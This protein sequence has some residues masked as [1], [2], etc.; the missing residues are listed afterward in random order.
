M[1]ITYHPENDYL[2]PDL[3]VP[4]APILGKYGMLRRR[5]LQQ[6]HNGLYTGLQL[7]GKLESHLTEIDQQATEMVDRL[8]NQLA[9]QQ[10][11]TE[12]LKASDQMQWVGLMNNCK[13]QAEA[14]VLRELIYQ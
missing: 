12:Q 9:Q 7:S 3:T 1:I 5:Y 6:Y 13:N 11:V 4:E 14:V 2:I 10:G 8:T